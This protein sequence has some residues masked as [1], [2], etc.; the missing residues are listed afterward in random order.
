VDIDTGKLVWKFLTGHFGGM[1]TG[2]TLHEDVL[3]Q[4]NREGTL[5]ALTLDGKEKW[6]FRI[7]N[8]MAHQFVYK[9]RIYFGTEDYNL[10]CLSLDG[11]I[12]WKFPTQGEIWW[13]PSA[14]EN[15]IFFT[16]MDC[17][18]YCVDI[19]THQLVWKFRGQGP[20]SYMGPPFDSYELKV[21]KPVEDTGL[22]EETEKKRYDMRISEEESPDTYTSRITYQLSSKYQSKGKYQI[23]SKEEEF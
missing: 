12:L 13:K 11:K 2:P 19:E 15:K 8:A 20:V 16:S 21:K 3:Y 18:L 22:K 9:D 14:W 6:N 4:T 7:N 10:Y 23:D 1:N 5:Y 17:Y